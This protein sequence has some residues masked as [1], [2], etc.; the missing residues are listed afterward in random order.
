MAGQPG[1]NAKAEERRRRKR[2]RDKRRKA[3]RELV[4]VAVS[5]R[6]GVPVA[7]AARA[8]RAA[9]AG[10]PLTERQAKEW[11]AH[12]ETAPSWLMELLGERMARAA[13]QE[14]QRERDREREEMRELA[15]EQSALAKVEAGKRRF[16][17]DE[18]TYVHDWAFRASKDLARGE[19]GDAPGDFDRKV[20]RAAGVDPE[21]HATW[22]VHLRGCD[23]EGK[24]HCA[25]RLEE[26]RA[27]RR[28]EA[29]VKS[30]AKE[31]ALREAGFSPGQVVTA[32]YGN[33]VGVV[34]K[35][36]RVSVKVRLVGG[37]GDEYAVLEKNLDPRY[38]HAAPESLP[39]PVGPGDNVVLR[40]HGGHVRRVRVAEADGPL[41]RADYALKSGQRRTAWFDVLA[42]RPGPE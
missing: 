42:L 26:I 20:L 36:N 18:W 13:E 19:P 3:D 11:A 35:V 30:V 40:D 33:R 8:M 25:E 17:D 6:L 34:V 29:L 4:P 38:V 10:G 23:G 39:A 7:E 14:Y 32:W 28:A 41:F 1:R 16:S 12:P 27:A 22:P 2:A 37:Q 24:D 9:G 31:T 15:A 5:Q 21:D